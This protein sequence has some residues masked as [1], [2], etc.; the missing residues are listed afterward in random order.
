M[1]LLSGRARRE[2]EE[3]NLRAPGGG[4]EAVEPSFQAQVDSPGAFPRTAPS[5]HLGRVVALRRGRPAM[6]APR[7]DVVGEAGP[8]GPG[9]AQ[10]GGC[11]MDEFP[12]QRSGGR[13]ARQ[14]ARLHR[15][16]NGR[17]F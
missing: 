16:W 12:R 6:S 8:V 1:A 3:A 11:V 10:Q 15:Q 9:T 4:R 17:P 14:A 13:A 2:I 7:P 5:T